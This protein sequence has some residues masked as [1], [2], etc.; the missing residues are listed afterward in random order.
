MKK[1]TKLANRYA[2]AL[3]VF[4]LEEKQL[5]TAFE[6]V[7]FIQNVLAENKELITII[8]SPIIAP[9]IKSNIFAQLFEDKINSMTYGFIELIIRKKR[10]PSISYILNAFIDHYHRYHNIKTATLTSAIPLNKELIDQIKTVLEEQTNSTIQIQT[11]IKPA[12][13]GG[14][15]IKVEDFL[16]D[17]SLLGKINRLKMEFAANIYQAGF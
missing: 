3:F 1:S 15:I 10:E 13:I 11:E 14:F 6:D 2:N 16:V 8:E 12:I 5:E 7:K 17:A 9:K 4:S